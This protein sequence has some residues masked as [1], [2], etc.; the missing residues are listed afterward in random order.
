[1][2]GKLFFLK[3]LHLPSAMIPIVN[4]NQ[5]YI[6]TYVCMSDWGFLHIFFWLIPETEK[7]PAGNARE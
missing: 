7:Y 3:S 4:G 5:P 2:I 6:C 1:M